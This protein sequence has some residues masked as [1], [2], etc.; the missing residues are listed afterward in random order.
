MCPDGRSNLGPPLASASEPRVYS[1]V[2][3]PRHLQ[4]SSNED[5]VDIQYTNLT[6]F[7]PLDQSPPGLFT[8]ACLYAGTNYTSWRINTDKSPRQD[9]YNFVD[10]VPP[11]DGSVVFRAV[12]TDRVEDFEGFL[13]CGRIKLCLSPLGTFADPELKALGDAALVPDGY[14]IYEVLGA[15]DTC[16]HGPGCLSQRRFFCHLPHRSYVHYV[17][18][19]LQCYTFIQDTTSPLL[20]SRMAVMEGEICGKAALGPNMYEAGDKEREWA[21]T[22]LGLSDRTAG[23]H[24]LLCFCPAFDASEGVRPVIDGVCGQQNDFVQQVGTLDG[25]MVTFLDVDGVVVDQILPMTRFTI[26]L[27]C[28]GGFDAC[29]ANDFSSI[30]VIPRSWSA[31]DTAVGASHWNK[32]NTCPEA[33]E[34]TQWYSPLNCQ[35]SIPFSIS[36]EMD[37]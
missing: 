12:Q 10:V 1:N 29:D 14:T 33:I 4:V 22:A 6:W 2:S 37:S 28:G 30:K 9:E 17:S 3:F 20:Y 8:G 34:T 11:L 7:P 27:D 32:S 25:L 5:V 19:D 15:M 18:R 16:P 21:R 31:E 36:K 26:R 24:Y 35:D 23:F 13:D